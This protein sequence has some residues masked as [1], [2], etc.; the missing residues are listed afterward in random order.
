VR[1]ADLDDAA[2]LYCDSFPNRV[3]GWFD[4]VDYAERFYRD[5]LELLQRT[6]GPTCF[7]AWSD[8]RLAG[9]LVL[10]TPGIRARQAL[11]M[12]GFVGRVASRIV[13]GEYGR[14]FTMLARAVRARLSAG[15]RTP[16]HM[17]DGYSHVSVLAVD[18][19]RAGQGIG[20]ALIERARRAASRRYRGIWLN[21]DSDN[22]AAIR[23]YQRMGFRI[24][25]S[26]SEQ[27]AMLVDLPQS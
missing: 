12:A 17:L 8:G 5:L 22:S 13:H 18:R 2:R 10:T 14:P 19:R 6:Y 21:V 3:S 11:F 1:S 27:H 23:F 7:A 20:A 16:R 26:G 24:A 4:S 9:Y 15:R 25:L